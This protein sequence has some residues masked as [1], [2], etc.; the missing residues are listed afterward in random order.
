MKLQMVY[1]PTHFF[2]HWNISVHT[3]L[4]RY[5]YS[6]CLPP[7]PTT[8][9]TQKASSITFFVSGLWHGFHPT[10]FVVFFHFYLFTLVETQIRRFLNNLGENNIVYKNENLFV[11]FLRS[12][13]LLFLVPYHVAMFISLNYLK[14]LQF[15]NTFYWSGTLMVVILNLILFS[16]NTAFKKKIRKEE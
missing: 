13:I 4:K 8:L 6:R 10:Y 3:Y 14:L 15:L 7:N 1:R 12:F 16:F 9:E 5:I 11:F 2:H